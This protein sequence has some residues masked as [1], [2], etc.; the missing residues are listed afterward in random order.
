MTVLMC[1]SETASA[2]TSSSLKSTLGNA[3][4]TAVSNTTRSLE[5]DKSI[6]SPAVACSATAA[7]TPAAEAAPSSASSASVPSS[8]DA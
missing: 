3:D 8:T 1:A 5:P 6:D 7:A 4:D 2:V